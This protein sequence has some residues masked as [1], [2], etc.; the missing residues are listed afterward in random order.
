LSLLTAGFRQEG[1]VNEAEQ[2]E[3]ERRTAAVRA[4]KLEA[5]IKGKVAPSP[6]RLTELLGD[7]EGAIACTRKRPSRMPYAPRKKERMA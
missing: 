3:I 6:Q 4:G 2:R 5:R 7:E 1:S